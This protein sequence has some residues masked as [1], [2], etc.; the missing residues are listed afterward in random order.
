MTSTRTRQRTVLVAVAVVLATLVGA[1]ALTGSAVA[2][3]NLHDGSTTHPSTGEYIYAANASEEKQI[4]YGYVV[5]NVTNTGESVELYLQFEDPFNNTAGPQR[6]SSFSGNVTCICGGVP[7]SIGIASSA[8]IIDGPDGDGNKETIKIGVQPNKRD[9]PIDLIVNFTGDVTW[10]DEHT[11]VAYNVSGAV[12]E[13]NEDVLPAERFEDIIVAGG[14]Y[15]E[16]NG[17]Y[18]VTGSSATLSAHLWNLN[19]TSSTDLWYS[20]WKE[21]Q[22]SSTQQSTSKMKVTDSE[23][24]GTFDQNVSGLDSGARYVF[25]SKVDNG[26]ETDEGPT[27]TFSPTGLSVETDD[28]REITDTNATFDGDLIDTGGDSSADVRFRYWEKGKKSET[29]SATTFET[30]DTEGNYSQTVTSLRNDTTYVVVAEVENQ[31]GD[32]DFGSE[33]EFTTAK[34]LGVDTDSATDTTEDSA[35]LN[36]NLTGLAGADSADVRFR[37]WEQGSKSSTYTVT[38]SQSVSSTGTFSQS[39]SGLDDNTTYTYVAEV[40]E[41][42][43]VEL[44]SEVEF[45]TPE[46]GVGIESASNVEEDSATLNGNLTGLGGDSSVDV[47]FRYW[48][49]GSKSS[50]YTVTDSQSVSATGSFSQSVSGLHN[51]TTYVY[52][53]EAIQSDGDNTFS[54]ESEFTTPEF[55][56]D[57]D[58]ASSVGSNSATLNGNLTGLGG[59]SSVDVRFRYWEQGSKSSTYTVT[60]SQSVS[61]TGSF[62]QSVSGLNSGTTYVYVAEVQDSDG[63]VDFGSEVEFTTS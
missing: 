51:N 63:N 26:K 30:V 57:T 24:P 6:L 61:S 11:N 27:F 23:V 48:E 34:P 2:A 7:E 20:Y 41:S 14:L 45:S 13:P 42:G 18:A 56:V 1:I 35:T 3:E 16:T 32:V 43:D 8:S 52:V 38:D 54:G 62:S 37:Y 60:D 49:Q 53:A 12:D 15:T 47:R 22:K 25:K 29:Y 21:G 5:E 39:V 19:G 59:D 55:N 58:P 44:G 46:F 50:T 33:V 9:K 4:T 17:S 10:T 40:Q 31:S 28:P 36:G